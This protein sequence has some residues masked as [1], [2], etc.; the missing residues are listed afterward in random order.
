VGRRLLEALASG[1][2]DPATLAGITG[3]SAAQAAL[4]LL[5]L[6]LAGVVRRT[7]LGGYELH[8]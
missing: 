2:R 5:D 7:V 1:P 3:L 8:A 6:E 4:E